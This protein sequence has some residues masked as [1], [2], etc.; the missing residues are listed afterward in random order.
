MIRGFTCLLAFQLVGELLAYALRLPISGPVC[1][2]AC[3]LIWLNFNESLPDE[4]GTVADALLKNMAVLFVPA[5]VGIMV[6]GD[7]FMAVGGAIVVALVIGAAT[8]L[9]VTA[10]VVELVARRSAAPWYGRALPLVHR[11]ASWSRYRADAGIATPPS[12]LPCASREPKL[13]APN[14]PDAAVGRAAST[15]PTAPA[16]SREI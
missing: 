5:G 2:M 10:V 7:A 15:R 12:M 1:G 8:T 11:L 9:V 14:F 13:A 3:L 4:V 16:M 6:F